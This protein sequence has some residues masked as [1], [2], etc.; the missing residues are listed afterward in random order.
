MGTYNKIIINDEVILDLSSDTITTNN[1]LEGV[2]AHDATG[3]Q[4]TGKIKKYNK[5]YAGDLEILELKPIMYSYNGTVLPALP[6]WDKVSYPYAYIWKV[7]ADSTKYLLLSTTELQYA[8]MV[9]MIYLSATSD[10]SLI[11]YKVENSEWLR[12]EETDT[13]FTTTTAILQ[14]FNT[15]LV[16]ANY[17]VIKKANGSV[18]LSASE[19]IPV[20]E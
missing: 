14:T 17:D 4:I 18:F 12:D 7:S 8:M 20:Y 16:W 9:N 6:E 11:A 10:G 19:P 3:I 1:L 13:S 15:P 2:T 5:E